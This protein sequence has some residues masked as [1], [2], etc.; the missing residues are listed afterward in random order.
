MK[1]APRPIRIASRAAAGFTLI[2]LLLALSIMSM[3]L[4]AM[5]GVL[6][7][8][9]R[10]QSSATG[11]L[12]QTMPVEQALTGIQHDLANIVCNNASN[13][14]MLIGSFQ[15]INRTNTLADQIPG[16]PDFYTTDGEPDGLLPWGDVEKIDYLL[17]SSTNRSL[18]GRDLVRAITRNLL[19]VN[20]SFPQ[21]D[22]KRTILSG[23]QSVVFS[24]YDGTTWE[25]NWDSTQQTN[26]PYGI[27]M[28]IQMAAQGYGRAAVPSKT[29]ELYIPVDVQ[30][31]TNYTVQLP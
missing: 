20:N 21:P 19:P 15:T 13:N 17:S 31:S 27:K 29:Y 14:V 23:V 5:S 30:M 7:L 12:D 18:Q 6:Y 28:T 9:Y 16:S 2:E 8:A 24:Y 10:M 1:T 22:Q 26:L 25:Q 4:A 11:A 3:I